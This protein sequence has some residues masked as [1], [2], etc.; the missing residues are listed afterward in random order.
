MLYAYLECDQR[1]RKHARR[2]TCMAWRQRRKNGV[3]S[4]HAAALGETI[5]KDEELGGWARPG[6]SVPGKYFTPSLNIIYLVSP[7]IE[8]DA[9]SGDLSLA[10]VACKSTVV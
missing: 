4:A 9:G 1:G 8:F 6:V 7:W 10:T 5:A 2:Y 3:L